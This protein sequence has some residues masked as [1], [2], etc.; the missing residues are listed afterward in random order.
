[1]AR[2]LLNI[3]VSDP[4]S[5]FFMLRRETV[6]DL[7]NSLAPEGFKILLDIMASTPRPLKVVEIPFIFRQR[8]AGESKLDSLVTAEYLGLLVSKISGGLLPVRFL[9]FALVGISGIIIHLATLRVASGILLLSFAW[10]QFAATV[11][12]M[13]WN[14]ILNNQLT[15]RDRRLNGIDF[16]YGLIT[17][18]AVCSLGTIA[19]VGASSWIY[20]MSPSITLAGLCGAVLGSVFNYAASSTLTWR[21]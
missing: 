6:E 13:T 11:V 10:A 8:Q 16:L 19:N 2:R 1:M 5:G 7:T 18:Y 15:Y 14:F 12:A 4:M 3:N 17:F 9:M 20:E 21:K